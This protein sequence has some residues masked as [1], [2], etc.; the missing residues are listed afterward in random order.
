MKGRMFKV[1]FT[2]LLTG[3]VLQLAVGPVF[4][5]ILSISVQRPLGDAVWAVVAVTSVDYLYISL[6][7]LGIGKLLE[8]KKIRYFFGTL[9]AAVLS[10]FGAAMVVSAVRTMSEGVPN[11]VSTSGHVSSFVSA[12]VLTIC[13]PLTIVFWTSLFASK[14]TEYRYTSRELLQFGLSAGLA[15]PLFLGLS[16]A[17]FSFLGHAI[18]SV[19]IAF[20]NAS[21]GVTLILYGVLR[22]RSVVKRSSG[23]LEHSEE[24]T[25]GLTS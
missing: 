18:P 17:L 2:G 25:P 5:L 24:K 4:F 11:G 9:G 7:I 12:F 15:T 22:L 1:G 16:V 14:A 20:L 10:V 23:S 3:L 8:K 13:S 19:V 6:A 21:V